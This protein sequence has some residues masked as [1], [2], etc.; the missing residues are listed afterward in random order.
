MAII[1]FSW[2]PRIFNF[3]IFMLACPAL[4]SKHTDE[5]ISVIC[6]QLLALGE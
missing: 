2:G 3:V 4:R 1:A 5:I 6:G